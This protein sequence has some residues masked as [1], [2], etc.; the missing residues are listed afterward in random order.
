[1]PSPS[2]LIAAAR[3]MVTASDPSELTDARLRRAISTAYY[4]VFHTVLHAAAK[5]FM[6]SGSK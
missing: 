6:G 1:M 4:A 5:R 3:F 2:E